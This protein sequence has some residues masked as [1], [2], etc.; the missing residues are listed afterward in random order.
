MQLTIAEAKERLESLLAEVGLPSLEKVVGGHFIFTCEND[1]TISHYTMVGIITGVE[2]FGDESRIIDIE[3]ILGEEGEELEG[4]ENCTLVVRVSVPTLL[5][6]ELVGFVSYSGGGSKIWSAMLNPTKEQTAQ[7][8]NDDLRG[9]F[10][11]I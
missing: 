6:R 9:E 3:D 8:L 7:G 11:L 2:L 5:D 1:R 10:K 4:E